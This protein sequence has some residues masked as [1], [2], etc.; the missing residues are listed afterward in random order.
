MNLRPIGTMVLSNDGFNENLGV[1]IDHKHSDW[2]DNHVIQMVD[3]VEHAMHI[4][5]A[6]RRGIG[7][8]VATP[9]QIARA[10]RGMASAAN[11]D[12]GYNK[13][14]DGDYSSWLVANNID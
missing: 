9:D 6:G 11:R 3:R 1:V 8:V 2:G 4:Y 12:A 7:W 5:D 14:R 13:E 10:L